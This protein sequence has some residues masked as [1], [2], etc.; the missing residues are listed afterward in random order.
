MRESLSQKALSIRRVAGTQLL[1]KTVEL[2]S[3]EN[4]IGQALGVKTGELAPDLCKDLQISPG[5]RRAGALEGGRRVV[6]FPDQR[7]HFSTLQLHPQALCRGLQVLHH[8][9]RRGF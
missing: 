6:G 5:H 8:H 9:R 1:D 3:I 7:Q 4:R 2:C